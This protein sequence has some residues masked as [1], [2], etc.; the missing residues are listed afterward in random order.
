MTDTIQFNVRGSVAEI[1]LN[2]P[3]K[4]NSLGKTELDALAI[5][6][7]AVANDAGFRV[8]VIKGAGDKTF[9]GGASLVD[10]RSGAI[11]GD[12]FQAVTD[13]ISSLKIPTVAAL[14]G[15]V[16]GGGAELALSCD[17]RI[18]CAGMILRVPPATMGLCYPI[19]G[20]CTFV[21]KLGP[22]LSKRLLLAAEKL[23]DGELLS[24]GFLD[25]LVLPAE[26]ELTVDRY[27]DQLAANAP[28]SVQ[29]MKQIVD[30]I[31]NGELDHKW[32]QAIADQCWNS[33][34][35]QEGLAAQK[36]KRTPVFNGA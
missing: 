36:D 17:F 16:F 22:T 23:E 12:D 5:C 24:L 26:F 20:I 8:L 15:S 33:A 11:T 28:L 29:G 32:A 31:M 1:T 27:A 19:S 30:Q 10:L 14:N 2:N 3:A 25:H 9:C 13:L 34:D 4:H 18:G 7:K 6:L 35:L 21:R